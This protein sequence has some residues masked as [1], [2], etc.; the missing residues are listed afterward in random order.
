MKAVQILGEKGHAKLGLTDSLPRPVPQRQEV[1]IQVHSAGVTADEISWPE[2]YKTPSRVPGHDI[3]GVVAGL[4]PDYCGPLTVGTEVF[5][6]LHADRG[7]GQAEYVTAFDDEI[8][9]KPKTIGH[10]EAS[11]LP[12][13]ILTAFEGLS[14]HAKLTSGSR[15][16]VTGAS[17]AVGVMV[18]QL[19]KRL[20][21]AH[22]VALA[23]T[24][25]HGYLRELGAAEVV[26]Y[27]AP[28]WEDHVGVGAVFDT[29]G[30][31]V[32]SQ[33]WGALKDQ[34]SI[35]TVSDPP[36]PWAFSD[37]LPKELESH[38]GVRYKYFVVSTDSEALSKVA[39]MIDNGEVTCL[40]VV[41]F[42][43][44]DAVA[45]WSAAAQRGRKGKVVIDFVR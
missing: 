27:T 16:L 26:D 35:I 24:E 18:V 5:A 4:G 7:Q 10:S 17:G 2:V 6:M 28:G 38:P 43:V 22:V 20:F 12:I 3:S 36:P 19:A 8:A 13:P 40:P 31:A 44:S 21:N 33:S 34:G 9:L 15:I 45:A 14:Q 11:A 32:L 29:V 25:K 41:P 1:L 39:G 30:G 42:P 37:E 23:S